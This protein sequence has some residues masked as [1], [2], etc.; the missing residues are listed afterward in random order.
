MAPPP[1][2][3]PAGSWERK[4]PAHDLSTQRASRPPAPGLPLAASPSSLPGPERCQPRHVP[5]RENQLP[6]APRRP[7]GSVAAAAYLSCA[8]GSWAPASDPGVAHSVGTRTLVTRGN[9]GSATLKSA[10]QPSALP[11]SSNLPATTTPPV[12]WS[13]TAL[14]AECAR[15]RASL[16]AGG[17]TGPSRCRFPRRGDASPPFP[18]SPPHDRLRAGDRGKPGWLAAAR[19]LA[20]GAR[21]VRCGRSETRGDALPPPQVQQG[22]ARAQVNCLPDICGPRSFA[23]LSRREGT[24]VSEELLEVRSVTIN[25]RTFFSN[26]M[27][28]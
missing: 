6:G 1:S 28:K 2:P 14:V 13:A 12:L 22:V 17:L 11:P 23:D 18:F 7:P 10:R 5:A 4:A 9:P 25:I 19:R 26:L 3:P 27:T 15:V 8:P 24:G 21:E 16:R 20:G